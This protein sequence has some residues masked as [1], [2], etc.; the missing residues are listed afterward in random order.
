MSNSLL[1]AG[2]IISVISDLVREAGNEE[3]EIL[4]NFDIA[5]NDWLL[6]IMLRDGTS[7]NIRI[8]LQHQMDTIA[9]L[10]AWLIEEYTDL[11]APKPPDYVK[12]NPTISD[13]LREVSAAAKAMDEAEA[14]FNRKVHAYIQ[15][16]AGDRTNI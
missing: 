14:N 12:P 10:K 15:R 8:D 9:E 1:S 16:I 2:I 13:F 4:H 3:V 7:A 6:R 11:F 5:S